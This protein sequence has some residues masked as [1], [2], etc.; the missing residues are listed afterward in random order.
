LVY[1]QKITPTFN[2]V[3]SASFDT[4]DITLTPLLT[5][6][7]TVPPANI[8]VT[9]GVGDT[10]VL[11]F[12]NYPSNALPDGRYQLVVH[13]AGVTANG[14]SMSSD[15]TM[16]T[17]FTLAGDADRSGTV[18]SLDLNAVATNFGKPGTFSQ[19]DF[20]Y[21]GTVDI[22]DFNVL[23]GS[24]GIMLPASAPAVPLGSLFAKSPIQPND[25]L[26]AVLD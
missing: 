21:S 15:F 1:Q 9:P 2:E 16:P 7:S 10:I 24:F 23:A 25:N 6:S 3:V 20:N 19:G 4:S 22:G 18:N 17:F 12:Q 26:L 5:P 13:A 8:I 11:T 14:N